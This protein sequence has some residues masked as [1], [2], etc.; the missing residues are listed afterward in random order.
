MN[1]NTNTDKKKREKIHFL[2]EIQL[3]VLNYILEDSV[4][5]HQVE[6]I[7]YKTTRSLLVTFN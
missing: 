1:N 2:L 3:Q 7:Y 6:L 5:V 4:G